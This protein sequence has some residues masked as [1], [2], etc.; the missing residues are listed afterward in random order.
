MADLVF[1]VAKGRAGHLATLPET[2]DALIL[3]LLESSGLV[4]DSVMEDYDTLAA[5][6]AGASTEQTTM[7]RKT[8][9][10]VTSA[11]NDD[12][13]EW[14][15]DFDDVTYTA[16]SGNAVGAAVVCYDPDTGSGTDSD[17]IPL[18]KHD[19]TLTPDGN[20]VDITVPTAGFYAAQ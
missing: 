7:G 11:V 12:D 4:A 2:S 13:D 19:V 3:V 1:N 10:T 6:L 18:S 17:L 9:T 8:L 14:Q 5:I 20:D 16:A 15:A